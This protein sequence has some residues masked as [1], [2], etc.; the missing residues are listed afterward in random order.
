MRMMKAKPKPI[1]T[2]RRQAVYKLVIDSHPA[3]LAHVE[4]FLRLIARDMRLNDGTIYRL[5]VSV[6]EAVNN[7]ILHGNGSNPAK[8]VR[9]QCRRM[10]HCLQFRISDEGMGF[11]SSSLPDPLE[12]K[13]L[14]KEHGRGVFLMRTLMDSVTFRTLK[15]GSVVSMRLCLDR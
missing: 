11:D 2:L 10:N 3:S 6:T 7:A 4:S 9:I 14:L 12:E 5:Q 13:N 15:K 8:Q 1:R